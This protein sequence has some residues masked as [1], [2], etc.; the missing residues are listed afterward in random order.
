MNTHTPHMYSF[1]LFCL[2]SEKMDTRVM[3]ELDTLQFVAPS[4][5]AATLD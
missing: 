1:L 5:E 3:H 2:C 4:S